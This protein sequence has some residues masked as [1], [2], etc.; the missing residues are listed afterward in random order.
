MSDDAQLLKASEG[1][2]MRYADDDAMT[3]I[4]REAADSASDEES[5]DD[6]MNER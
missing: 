2:M 4:T 5:G 1:E 6:A 3:M